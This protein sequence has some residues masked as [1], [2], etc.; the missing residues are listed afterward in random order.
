MLRRVG[1]VSQSPRRGERTRK[2]AEANDMCTCDYLVLSIAPLALIGTGALVVGNL[3]TMIRDI[4]CPK[5]RE[6]TLSLWPRIMGV[7]K[8]GEEESVKIHFFLLL[9]GLVVVT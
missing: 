2:R 7:R 8:T 5:R 3:W 4:V 6:S 9:Y 1:L